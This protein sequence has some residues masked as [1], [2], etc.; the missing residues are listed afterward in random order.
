MAA[1][2]KRTRNIVKNQLSDNT[3][4]SVKLNSVYVGFV[5]DNSDALRMRRLRVWIPEL[6]PDPING[7]YTVNWCSPFAGAS[8]IKENNK[9]DESQTS[10]GMWFSPPDIDNEVVVMF[11][12]GDPNRGIYIGGMYQQSM[13]H[14][15]PG[16]PTSTLTEDM[17]VIGSSGPAQEYNKKNKTI[18][19]KQSGHQRPGY[20]SLIDSLVN[21]GLYSDT[22]RGISTSGA[23]RD[24]AS[25]VTGLLT[26]GGNQLVMDDDTDNSFIRFRTTNGTQ[27]V[28]NDTV[29]FIY[30]ITRAGN[31]WLELSDKGI[32]AYTAG[33]YSIRCTGDY[34]VH[35]DGDI[36]LFSGNFTN[37]NANAELSL[38]SVETFNLI[39]GNKLLMSSSGEI[40]I[41]TTADLG[42]S[43]GGNIGVDSG[44]IL[45]LRACSEIGVTACDKIGLSAS[46]I[47]NNSGSV[48]TPSTPGQATIKQPQS[49]SDNTVSAG[50][51][52]KST[53]TKSN[54]SVLVTHEPYTGHITSFPG[55]ATVSDTNT[56]TYTQE[57]TD[58]STA[59][60]NTDK[61]TYP[62]TGTISSISNNTI[63]LVSIYG[64][65][66]ISPRKGNVLL[67]TDSSVTINHLDGT[68]SVI[69]NLSSISV[70]AGDNVIQGQ[71]I[72]YVGINNLQA[73]INF[74]ITSNG[75]T[76]SPSTYFNNLSTNLYVTAGSS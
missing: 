74:N 54:V 55:A 8:P 60:G 38:S 75:Q 10:Y 12:N 15:V 19:S 27:I 18:A 51:K 43:G 34:N 36:N 29:G 1:T 76:V 28:I 49:L 71:N 66:V 68:Y 3:N 17:D 53:T 58:A 67:I 73:Y 59:T 23:R 11:A 7:L 14:M 31:S 13:N 32:N 72:G 62:V 40:G 47:Y 65:S 22:L 39:S 5:K 9:T 50:G 35:A 21:Q 26:P 41:T 48:S 44:G 25:K 30:M 42:I 56:V 45:A 20:T 69:S 57:T 70:N 46:N 37:I 61:W 24:D 63:T 2:G 33:D 6:S 64:Y 52:G 16:I 4:Q